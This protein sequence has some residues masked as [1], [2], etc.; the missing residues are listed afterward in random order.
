MRWAFCWALGGLEVSSE[1]PAEVWDPPARS[2]GPWYK[3]ELH[4]GVQSLR[5]TPN[6]RYPNLASCTGGG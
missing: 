3:E 6:Y 1:N 4:K 2:E 5:H